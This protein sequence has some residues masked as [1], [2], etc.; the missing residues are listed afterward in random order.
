MA[1]VVPLVP[2]PPT[3]S[4]TKGRPIH[5]SNGEKWT[6]LRP[7][8]DGDGKKIKNTFWMVRKVE[9]EGAADITVT[10]G[11]DSVYYFEVSHMKTSLGASSRNKDFVGTIMDEAWRKIA[12][13]SL[14]PSEV[15]ILDYKEEEA[16]TPASGSANPTPS[17]TSSDTQPKTTVPSPEK[18]SDW[19]KYESWKEGLK[20]YRAAYEAR[21]T[22]EDLLY[23]LDESARGLPELRDYLISKKVATVD[24]FLI[25]MEAEVPESW[26][27]ETCTLFSRWC[28]QGLPESKSQWKRAF[29]S[30]R[31][32][33]IGEQAE[34]TIEAIRS[35]P[36]LVHYEPLS[37]MRNGQWAINR[38][39]HIQE[40]DAEQ[41]C[42]MSRLLNGGQGCRAGDMRNPPDPTTANTCIYCLE[43]H[44]KAVPENVEHVILHCPC[45]EEFRSPPEFGAF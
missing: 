2:P 41:A 9:E 39:L 37:Y 40:I 42:L 10:I 3:I 18:F 17:T 22:V 15:R 27:A 20:K 36:G 8:L 23:R 38:C 6:Y 33:C 14:E 16:T 29:D 45:F 26:V 35:H 13:D 32:D 31:D 5:F 30:C 4:R 12:E 25:E 43:I 44:G 28:R 11:A 19:G 7:L 24:Q 34:E 21:M 1:D